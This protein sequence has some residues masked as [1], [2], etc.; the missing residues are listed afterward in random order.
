[1]DSFELNKIAGAVLGTLTFAVGLSV[2]SDIWFTP[3]QPEQQ[4]Y[5]IAVAEEEGE[6]GAAEEAGPSLA[7]L[8]ADADAEAGQAASRACASCHTFDEGGENRVGPN[9]YNIV[10]NAKAHIDGFNYSSAMEEQAAEGDLW[11]YEELDAFLANPS[12]YMPGTSMSYAGM[13]RPGQ[14]ADLITYLASISPDAPPPPEPTDEDVAAAENGEADEAPDGEAAPEEDAA[15]EDGEAAEDE[16][17]EGED[18]EAAEDEEAAAPGEGDVA[19]GEEVAAQV[20]AACHTFDEGG[21]TLVGPNLYGIYGEAVAAEDGYDYSDSFVE[22][23]EAGEVWNSETLD[24]FLADPDGWAPGTLMAIPPVEDD[25][26][27]HVIAYLRSISP[28]ADEAEPADAA[29][30]EP[31]EDADEAEAPAEAEEPAEDEAPAEE[32]AETEEPAADENGEAEEDAAAPAEQDAAEAE[33]PP[34]ADEPADETEAAG[35]AETEAGETQDAAPA[36]EDAA[37]E[38]G[39]AEPAEA[40]RADVAAAVAAGDPEAGQQAVR[41]CAACHTFDEG[42]ANRVGPNLYG[43]LG[44]PV[45]SIDGYDYSDALDA[46]REEGEVWDPANMD[47]F[48]EAPSQWASGTRMIFAGIRQEE[49]RADIIAYLNSLEGEPT[50]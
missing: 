3:S 2:F 27:G 31:A 47:A 38:P 35:A 21:E 17:T 49:R 10:G 25:D 46:K 42:G 8:L 19:M 40:A 5:E 7:V 44:Q 4:G 32:P 13:Q 26:R 1:M 34:A 12:G 30:E 20:C 11:G 9:L 15:P 24:A 48:L 23:G 6:N 43:I 18:A 39:E 33:T 36:Q 41:V 22:H 28:G 45:A 50:E 37:A 16:A 14:R 29:V